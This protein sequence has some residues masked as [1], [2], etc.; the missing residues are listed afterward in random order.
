MPPPPGQT[1]AKPQH[2]SK[3]KKRQDAWH[4]RGHGHAGLG[5]VRRRR[6]DGSELRLQQRWV[7]MLETGWVTD[8][9]R[10]ICVVEGEEKRKDGRGPCHAPRYWP[11]IL[12]IPV[13]LG[14]S[15]LSEEADSLSAVNSTTPFDPGIWGYSVS[16]CPNANFRHF[17]ISARDKKYFS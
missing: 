10:R 17:R 7:M 13:F 4:S 11:Q 14:S 15:L 1:V 5:S 3:F 2:L 8:S 12:L 6:L 16:D 9:E